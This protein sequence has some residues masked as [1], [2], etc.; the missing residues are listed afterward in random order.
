MDASR[1]RHVDDAQDF[2]EVEFTTERGQAIRGALHGTTTDELPEGSQVD[3]I[4]D[5]QHPHRF[6]TKDHAN[7]SNLVNNFLIFSVAVPA[8]LL[9]AVGVAARRMRRWK[10]ALKAG[11]WQTWTVSRF[12]YRPRSRSLLRVR[13]PG[14]DGDEELELG[15]GSGL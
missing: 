5:A 12:A 9:I 4:Y 13:G 7:H 10:Q 6:R 11:P 8:M 1:V 2:V 3:V 15:F 14:P